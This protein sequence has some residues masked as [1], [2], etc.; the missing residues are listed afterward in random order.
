[1]INAQRPVK[2]LNTSSRALSVSGLISS[3]ILSSGTPC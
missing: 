1:L 3:L 2:V